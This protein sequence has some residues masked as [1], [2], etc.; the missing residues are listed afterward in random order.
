MK[1]R[2]GSTANDHWATPKWLYDK[3]DE[4][5]HFDF[6]PCPLHAGFDGLAMEWGICNFVNPPYN[7]RDKPRFVRKAYEEWLKGKTSVLLIPAAT[8]TK[9]FHEVILPNAEIRFLK[10]RVNFAGY[11]SKGLYVT[12]NK[13]KHDSMIVIFRART[14]VSNDLAQGAERSDAPAGMTC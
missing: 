6:D 9:D 10:G 8:G 2:D 11:N 7:R 12:N 13:G 1:N 14:A 5:F 4:E 3:L